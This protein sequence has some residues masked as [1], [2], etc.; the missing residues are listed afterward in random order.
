MQTMKF[1]GDGGAQAANRATGLTI[2]LT[3]GP[4]TGMPVGGMPMADAGHPLMRHAKGVHPLLDRA[5]AAHPPPDH[6]KAVTQL[7]DHA[8]VETQKLYADTEHAETF[9]IYHDGLSLWWSKDAQDY[10][11]HR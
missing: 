10:L 8:V 6:A 2:G 3:H 11:E 9:L 5:K 1:S 7:M 4:P